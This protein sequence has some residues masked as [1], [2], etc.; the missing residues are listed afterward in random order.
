MNSTVAAAEAKAATM[1]MTGGD[2]D[3]DRD[4]ATTRTDNRAGSVNHTNPYARTTAKSKQIQAQ[5]EKNKTK[6][7][8]TDEGGAVFDQPMTTGDDTATTQ[9]K[10]DV[11][12][13]LLQTLERDLDRLNSDRKVVLTMK[14]RFKPELK[15]KHYGDTT[16]RDI[17]NPIVGHLRKFMKQSLEVTGDTVIFR[18]FTSNCEFDYKHCLRTDEEARKELL[19]EKKQHQKY[20]HVMMLRVV[21][22]SNPFRFKSYLN[23]WLRTN[24][25]IILDHPYPK[26]EVE[27]VRIGYIHSKHPTDTYRTDYQDK[28]N[29]KLNAELNKK[30]KAERLK[31]ILD[32]T[33]DVEGNSPQIRIIN[34]YISW[35][36]GDRKVE[37]RGLV[38]ECLK[39][40]RQFVLKRIPHVFKGT[41]VRFVPFSLPYDRNVT[42]AANQYMTLLKQH[43]KYINTLYTFPVLGLTEVMMTQVTP[44]ETSIK[45]QL[46]LGDLI[47]GVEKTPG[48]H[49]VGKWNLITTKRQ[50]TEAEK[51]FDGLMIQRFGHLKPPPGEEKRIPFR[52]QMPQVPI[53]YIDE[54]LVTDTPRT[55]ASTLSSKDASKMESKMEG[56]LTKCEATMTSCKT[57]IKTIETNSKNGIKSMQDD[58]RKERNE[59]KK[60]LN[61]MSEQQNQK[62]SELYEFKNQQEIVN[63]LVESEI[64]QLRH[65]VSQLKGRVTQNENATEELQEHLLEAHE[66]SKPAFTEEDDESMD[67]SSHHNPQG[68]S[69]DWAMK[70]LRK[71][72]TKPREHSHRYG[73]AKLRK[74]TRTAR[75][76]IVSQ[77]DSDEDSDILPKTRKKKQLE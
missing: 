38:V 70:R 55:A 48:T 54:V 39:V 29:T 59:F 68:A 63:D 18:T 30:D 43:K 47:V 16:L 58:W 17:E 37:T 6:K 15:Y 57:T 32:E 23:S 40:D 69:E 53:E 28:L 9:T 60:F 75:K 34:Q 51:Y 71:R 31:I 27:T 20:T 52:A 46:L 33:G 14:L 1:T 41:Q 3:G 5:A 56:I 66:P 22:V 42:D 24:N 65:E 25:T 4:D 35:G 2:S 49:W 7:A 12:D 67:L 76:K 74:S 8:R 45:D 13:P 26:K 19:A 44:E 10:T 64:D 21:L 11:D 73:L 72:T 61:D 62:F 36:R 50:H 77:E